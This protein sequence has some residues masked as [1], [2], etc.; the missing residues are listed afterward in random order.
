MKK[1]IE[2]LIAQFGLPD[3]YKKQVCIEIA[4]KLIRTEGE[5]QS[6][7]RHDFSDTRETLK[8]IAEGLYLDQTW[9]E[10]ECLNHVEEVKAER[11]QL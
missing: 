10:K 9:N 1:V 7:S 4:N 3:K 11:E 5:F 6:G 2:M 8:Y